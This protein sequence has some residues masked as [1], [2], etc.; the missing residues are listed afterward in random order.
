MNGVFDLAGTDGM[1]PVQSDKGSEPVFRAEWEKAAFSMFAQGAR[2]GL[3]NIDEFRHCIEKMDPAEYL[4]SNYYEHWTHVLEHMCQEHDLFDA[5]E[6][7]E[8]IQFYTANPDAPLPKRAD[9][10]ILEFVNGAI[11]SGFSA[12]RSTSKVRA[13]KVGDGVT[14]ASDSPTGHTRRAGY[15]RGRTGVVTAAP[16]AYVYPD[17]SGN[18]LGDCPEHVY[19]VKFTATELWG[20]KTADPASSVCFDVWE[21]YITHA[22]NNITAGV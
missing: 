11:T 9:P 4:L 5:S 19:T 13:F 3:F 20:E 21:P 22:A 7:E 15:I 18:G 14:V 17:T 1:G 2:A 6:L 12:A 16:G 10:D 8:R